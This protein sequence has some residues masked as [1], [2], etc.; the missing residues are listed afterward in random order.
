MDYKC[1]ILNRDSGP[2][3]SYLIVNYKDAEVWHYTEL[4]PCAV[5][6][7]EC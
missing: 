1:H 2:R 6:G 3:I 4:S 5:S 7:M